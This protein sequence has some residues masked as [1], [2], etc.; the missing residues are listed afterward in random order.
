MEALVAWAMQDGLCALMD[1]ALASPGSSAASVLDFIFDALDWP[2]VVHP[3]DD[4]DYDG[5]SDLAAFAARLPAVI[6]A[7]CEHDD[8]DDWLRRCLNNAAK[9]QSH[10]V[11]APLRQHARELMGCVHVRVVEALDGIVVNMLWCLD[12]A[13]Y[14]PLVDAVVDRAIDDAAWAKATLAELVSGEFDFLHPT[15]AARLPDLRPLVHEQDWA[16]SV[17]AALA[18]Q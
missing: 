14:L 5:P 7:V 18:D 10:A 8:T 15:L 6:A 13:E 17:V 11:Q 3:D 9:I 16:A 1:E 12:D 4:D 2:G